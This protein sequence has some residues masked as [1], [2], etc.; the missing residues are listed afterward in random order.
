MAGD[1]AGGTQYNITKTLATNDINFAKEF[2]EELLLI[3][4]S[5][6]TFHISTIL[7]ILHNHH[8]ENQFR[9]ILEMM[10]ST[11]TNIIKSS[12]DTI[13]RIDITQNNIDEVFK[14][15]KFLQEQNNEKID[16]NVISCC[17]SIMKEYS[18]FKD[19]LSEYSNTVH[20]ET[21]YQLSHILML[22]D[23]ECINEDWYQ[24][25]LFS[26][27]DT[28]FEHQGIITNINFILDELIKN[29][30]NYEMIKEFLIQWSNSSNIYN[31]MTNNTL[32][33][34]ISNFQSEQPELLNK[35]ITECLNTEN[36]RIH[37]MLPYF[38]SSE[39]ILDKNILQLFS[40][41]EMLFVC[42]KILG[43][44]YKFEEIIN[45]IFSILTVNELSENTHSI[46]KEVVVNFI[47]KNYPYN[48]LEYFKDL[49]IKDLN[50]KEL[51]FSSYVIEVL[52][53]RNKLYKELPRLNELKSSSKQD[54]II[55]RANNLSMNKL[56][57]EKSADSLFSI[58]ASNKILIKYGK[59][60]IHC[61]N[62]SYGKPMFLQ[63]ISSSVTM[64]ISSRSHP[65]YAESERYGFKLAKK[66]DK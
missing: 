52:E 28:P 46:L 36:Y 53:N 41:N 65:I 34:F 30:D 19:I 61:Q 50:T 57:E 59:G 32:Q 12:L 25:C 40:D 29:I 44:F 21:K 31:N 66:G 15:V 5:Y 63:T 23:K 38:I 17:N 2:L 16:G 62:G 3:D 39:T 6:A 58:I 14:A 8:N 55:N 13:G 47:G 64:P 22:N 20:S 11:D 1:M 27:V 18:M 48:T 49:D 4:E 54:R 56:M 7:T 42:R 9:R 24:K 35:F 26:L 10:N 43:Y 33:I 37:L 45:L 51:E 60:S